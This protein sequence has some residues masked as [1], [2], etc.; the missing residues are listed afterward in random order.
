M[1]I[2]YHADLQLFEIQTRNTSYIF[3][4][5]DKGSLQQ[6]YWGEI[7]D[8]RE[9]AYLLKSLSH[10]SFDA[11]VDRDAE[12]YGGAGGTSY[13]GSFVEGTLQGWS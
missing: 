4:I 10:S 12:E 11:A 1:A 7:I 8:A 5:N 2:T 13:L 9:C 6:V 3:G